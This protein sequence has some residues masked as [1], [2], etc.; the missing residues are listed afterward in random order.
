[1]S[2][3][4]LV[5]PSRGALTSAATAQLLG[6]AVAAW[7]A[8][9]ARPLDVAWMPWLLVALQAI[10][11]GGVARALGMAPWWV[12][13]HLAFGPALLAAPGVGTFATVHD[14]AGGSFSIMQPEST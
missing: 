3:L 2:G 1:M 5:P 4:A 10:C 8:S 7:L 11:A 9:I 12:A 14:P 6:L 13:L